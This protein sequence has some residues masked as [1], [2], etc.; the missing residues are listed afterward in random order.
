MELY[1]QETEIKILLQFCE[2]L[3][4]KSV[5]D[6]GAEK[7][8]FID[9]FLTGGC[10]SIYAF[11]PYPSHIN[12]LQKL[13]QSNAAVQIF[14]IAPGEAPL[15]LC[16]Q[17]GPHG[18][19]WILVIHMLLRALLN[20]LRPTHEVDHMPLGFLALQAGHSRGEHDIAEY[21]HR[22]VHIKDGVVERDEVKR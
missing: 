2:R 15:T 5:V 20:P 1:E 17:I 10:G 9:A 6:V 22:V 14:P 11:E 19:G 16:G 12:H 7:G 8:S 18:R 3:N 21:A 4:N 13:F